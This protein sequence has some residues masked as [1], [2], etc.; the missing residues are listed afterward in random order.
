[1]HIYRKWL[2]DI[3]MPPLT[4]SI[5]QNFTTPAL[6]VTIPWR[7]KVIRIEGWK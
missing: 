6:S 3:K 5:K 7:N 2:I 1:M 4:K